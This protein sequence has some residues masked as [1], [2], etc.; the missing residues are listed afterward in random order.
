M[1]WQGFSRF[2]QDRQDEEDGFTYPANTVR[3]VAFRQVGAPDGTF[4]T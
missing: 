2:L 3:P 1:D 4:F